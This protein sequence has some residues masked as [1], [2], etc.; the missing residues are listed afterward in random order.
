MDLPPYSVVTLSIFPLYWLYCSRLISL[1][2][3]SV[4]ASLTVL[5][6]D[7]FSSCTS[8]INYFIFCTLLMFL[9]D[10]TSL[11]IDFVASMWISFVWSYYIVCLL[12]CQHNFAF[13]FIF[14]YFFIFFLFFAFF[15][16]TY[17]LF[18]VKSFRIIVFLV[19]FLR[20][21]VLF[22]Y[23][24]TDITGTWSQKLIE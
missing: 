22:S 5:D 9:V 16:P 21:F 3:L 12:I 17:M 2:H 13:L 8:Q 4:A 1:Y 19:Y 15:Y 18:F 10:C 6:Y 20:N 11:S 23:I 7:F 24:P 14:F